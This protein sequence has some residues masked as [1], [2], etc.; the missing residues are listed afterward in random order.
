MNT[1]HE[2]KDVENGP[3]LILTKNVKSVKELCK[4]M[5]RFW[6]VQKMMIF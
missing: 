1:F 5:I 4:K 2:E 3:A 6:S